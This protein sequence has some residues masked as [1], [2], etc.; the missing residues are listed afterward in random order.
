MRFKS[1]EYLSPS[2]YTM[3][4][5]CLC[6]CFIISHPSLSFAQPY[7]EEVFSFSGEV[8]NETAFRVVRPVSFT[9]IL[10]LLR[11]EGRYIPNS[12]LQVTARLRSFYDFVYDFQT[13]DSI[14]PRRNPRTILSDNPT[15]EELERIDINNLRDAQSL[16]KD[17]E[18]REF[19]VDLMFRSVDLRIGRQI[20]R[21]G[22]LE[23]ARI[24]DEI[25]PLD[26]HEFILREVQDR[27]IPLWMV[28]ADFYHG[29]N[30]TELLW[31]PD[32]EFHRPAKPGSEWEQLQRL[33]NLE[34]PAQ[35]FKNSEW[36][37]RTALPL[38]QWDVSFSYFYTWDD[39]PSAF[40]TIFDLGQFGVPP[41]VNFDPRHTRLHILGGSFSKG[42]QTFVF[43]SEIAYIHGKQFGTR[44][45][46]FN[47]DSGR[48]EGTVLTL[49]EKERDYLK[50]GIG[51]DF[52]FLGWETSWMAIQQFI[53]NHQSDIIQDETDTLFSLFFRKEF[54][55]SRLAF[56]TLI[57]Y[58]VNDIETLIRPK[59]T[60]R[61]NNNVN[62]AFGAD[63]FEGEIGG[64]LPGNFNFVGFFKNHDRVY[65]EISYGF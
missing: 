19:F 45:G 9:K 12:K 43:N 30:K 28:K 37:I 62:L 33:E 59:A 16:Q 7:T 58:F 11:L 56:E 26:L 40:R 57:L 17:T 39:F 1:G 21:W 65:V 52:R 23:G 55:S 42:F 18:L 35:N 2:F 27:Y 46:N 10:N 60:Y 29:I 5:S 54:Q 36:A 3:A 38:G 47:P 13:I 25:N 4:L 15:E 64:P 49:G 8:K 32:L 24:T 20:V 22:V 50:Y 53:I 6:L 41:G 61:I 14:S 34:E 63:I 44:L 48:F 31:I 51:F